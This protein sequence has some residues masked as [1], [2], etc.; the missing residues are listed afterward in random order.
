VPTNLVAT[1][2]VRVAFVDDHRSYS[3]ALAAAFEQT[4]SFDVVG[5]ASTPEEAHAVM[6]G[7][8]DVALVDIEL[9]GFDGLELTKALRRAHPDTRIVALS[10]RRDPLLLEQAL[11]SG[12]SGFIPKAAPLEQL[13]ESVEATLEDRASVPASLLSEMFGNISR[14]EERKRAAMA[15][16]SHL[17][18]RELEILEMVGRGMSTREIAETLVVSVN[19]I[20]THVQNVL[21]KLNA[22]SRIEAVNY[23]VSSGLIDPV[24]RRAV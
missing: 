19:T 6:A 2:R 12:A 24:T 8:V 17:T 22:H 20:R 11:E 18:T 3:Q 5:V 21:T 16:R 1:K 7:G 10:G 15:L 14:R 13:I 23:A 4:G 9:D